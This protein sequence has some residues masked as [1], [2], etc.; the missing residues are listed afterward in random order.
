MMDS[1]GAVAVRGIYPAGHVA[2]VAMFLIVA[3]EVLFFRETWISLFETWIG[4]DTY[5]YG[6]IVPLI[7]A[8]LLFRSR[9][10]WLP[11][12]PTP[13]FL[14]VAAT[15]VASLLWAVGDLAGIQ[16]LQHFA[17]LA[18]IPSAA[19]AVFGQRIMRVVAFP[20]LYLLLAT[21][22]GEFLVPALIS[23]TAEFS[24]K[25]VE[26]L[27]IPVLR[28]G[29]FIRTSA[30]DFHVIKACSGI[31]YLLTAIVLGVL[32]ARL[33][34]RSWWRR[35]AFIA[36]CIITPLVANW[37]RAVCIILIGHFSDMK[38]AAGVD[39]F[40]YGWLFFGIVMLVIFL[41]GA[42]FSDGMPEEEQPTEREPIAQAS[43]AR[44]LII[45]I[46]VSMTAAAGGM[47]PQAVA[48]LADADGET[49]GRLEL[50]E[51]S[52]G[53][54]RQDQA[55]SDWSPVFLGARLV[56]MA[57]YV[58]DEQGVSAIVVYYDT[59]SQGAEI[60]N[61]ENSL[62]DISKWWLRFDG[63]HRIVSGD[64]KTPFTV[65]EISVNDDNRNR[66]IW[67]WYLISGAHY[68]SEFLAKLVTLRTAISGS[69]ADSY[70]VALSVDYAGDIDRAR[71]TM[72]TFFGDHRL[73]LSFCSSEMNGLDASCD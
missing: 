13:S 50:P 55:L 3:A 9:H 16:I 56:D 26:V 47:I 15:A 8:A 64:L 30:G 28:E 7:S 42:R 66:L 17:V 67:S 22:F 41:I 35:I 33:G 6:L 20:F 25:A 39:H 27:G 53:W 73:A 63:K 21:P 14:G 69:R 32:F 18:L 52:A 60:V 40:V 46:A 31:R 70:L 54:I 48:K 11:L 43:I 58:Q 44:V 62:Y 71:E 65:R 19:L 36:L 4:I 10:Q 68:S 1:Q 23:W 38:L 61:I 34:F 57:S 45:L 5:R 37:I 59:Q 72:A 49:V 24:V 51:S 12:T 29:P 2:V